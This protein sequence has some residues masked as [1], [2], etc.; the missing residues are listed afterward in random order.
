[1][2]PVRL[3]DQIAGVG[4]KLDRA[5]E[6][7][8]AFD[9]EWDEWRDRT[10]PWGATYEVGDN[11]KRIIFALRIKHAPPQRFGV[12]AGEIVHDLRSALDHLASYFVQFYGSQPTLV[13]AWPVEPSQWSW[14]RKVE[15]R[16]RP[17]QLWRKKGGGPLK[18][19]PRGSDGWTLIQG[20]QP[21]IRSDKARDDPLWNL[22]QLWNADKH[23]TLTPMPIFASPAFVLDSFRFP[24]QQGD[25]TKRR[26][27]APVGK[28]LK[29]GTKLAL[30]E[31]ATPFP[32]MQVQI[33]L[34][35]QIALGD[36]KADRGG[37][38]IRDILQIVRDLH[39]DAA[40]IPYPPPPPK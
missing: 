12:M 31:F 2:L 9:A 37:L 6:L 1:M 7:L 4:A 16:S 33:D 38:P 35:V 39:A 19:V 8:D 11:F 23:R 10:E 20:T 30:F 25:P 36:E 27:L 3:A 29:D 26:M 32:N 21:Y 15:R 5:E 28:P 18:G 17:W 34:K 13:T 22:H 40:A 14:A 24:P